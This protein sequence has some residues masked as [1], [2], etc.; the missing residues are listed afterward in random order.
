MK[1]RYVCS[2]IC[3]LILLAGISACK[4]EVATGE[5]TPEQLADLGARIYAN[6]ENQSAILSDAGMTEA[7]FRLQIEN[8]S[9]ST[10]ASSR[11]RKS[12]EQQLQN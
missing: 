2:V 1:T 9:T 8:I 11:Y 7:D 4:N 12:F 3:S 10:D 6:P 5:L